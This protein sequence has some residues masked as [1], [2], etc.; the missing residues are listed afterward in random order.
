M[1]GKD[2]KYR[3]DNTT[4]LNDV[5]AGRVYPVIAA[6]GGTTPFAVYD[7]TSIRTE[8]SKDA[9]SHIDIVNVSI[10]MVGSDYGILQQA[11]E[12]VRTAFVRIKETIGGVEVQSCGFDNQ[13]EVFN[14]DEMTFGVEVDLVFRIVKN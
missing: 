9:D 11:V 3:F 2:I 13:T 4:A 5:F 6:Q 1:I 12:D 10:T 14:V 8:G 7:V